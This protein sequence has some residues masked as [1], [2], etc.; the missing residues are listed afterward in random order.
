MSGK[1]T[2]ARPGPLGGRARAV[3][4]QV[5]QEQRGPWGR[6]QSPSGAGAGQWQGEPGHP[7]LQ[8]PLPG[9]REPCT[10]PSL[11]CGGSP[12]RVAARTGELGRPPA[13]PSTTTWVSL[14]CGPH[15][16][17]REARNP[18][19]A[20]PAP[21]AWPALL[22][23]SIPALGRRGQSWVARDVEASDPEEHRRTS[24]GQSRARAGGQAGKERRPGSH[25][26]RERSRGVGR[27]GRGA[28]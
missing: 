21:P 26:G 19:T 11:C 4:S 20:M 2:L 6:A 24:D 22:R 18:R 25:K 15:G 8:S 7:A 12:H 16:L 28:A 17:V 13:V 23:N 10:V 5:K 14:D 9:D 27:R 1:A 3:Q